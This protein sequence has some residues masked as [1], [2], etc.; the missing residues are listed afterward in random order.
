MALVGICAGVC[1]ATVNDLQLQ[2]VGVL[3]AIGAMSLSTVYKVSLSLLSLPPSLPPSVCPQLTVP[4]CIKVLTSKLQQQQTASHSAAAGS[5]G[6]TGGRWDSLS[7]MHALLPRAAVVLIVMALL[8]ER[9]HVDRLCHSDSLHLI[10][11]LLASSALAF[12]TTLATYR[13]VGL[14][15]ALTSSLI[16]QLK[17][18]LVIVG[19][20]VFFAQQ[21]TGRQLVGAACALVC[22]SFYSSFTL[23]DNASAARSLKESQRP[24]AVV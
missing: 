13:V 6:D 19:G 22:F 17:T 23:E 15:S 4:R 8:F 20:H 18:A 9:E 16:G 2:L 10:G 1:V 7:L 24:G 14:A 11:L 21:Q 12:I 3:S 5:G